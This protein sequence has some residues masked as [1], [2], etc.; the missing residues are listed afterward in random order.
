MSV[1]TLYGAS[2][3]SANQADYPAEFGS[4]GTQGTTVHKETVVKKSKIVKSQ[5]QKKRVQKKQVL[6]AKATGY[7]R[8]RKAY[9]KKVVQVATLDEAKKI[10]KS[11]KD[12]IVFDKSKGT[13]VSN[14]LNGLFN[15]SKLVIMLK[16][17]KRRDG[18]I[19]YNFYFFKKG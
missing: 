8:A 4:K 5:S 18:E 19:L 16:V 17:N 9:G 1:I 13:I 12:L 15:K 10:A 3:F 7:E 6:K 14:S 11:R 2:E